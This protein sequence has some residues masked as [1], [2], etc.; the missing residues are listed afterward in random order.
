MQ[1]GIVGGDR[2]TLRRGQRP[3][4]GRHL[5]A[6]PIAG[7]KIVELLVQI[8][9][10]LAGQPRC[11]LFR[12]PH[13]QRAMAPVAGDLIRQHGAFGDLAPER[14]LARIGRECG[15]PRER[16][17]QCKRQKHHA[18]SQAGPARPGTEQR[19]SP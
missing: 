1:R 7:R 8:Q 9:A 6:D 15:R 14:D 19:R 2:L 3:G 11:L 18:R 16:Q 12:P 4:D 17:K 13:A 10:R 5:F